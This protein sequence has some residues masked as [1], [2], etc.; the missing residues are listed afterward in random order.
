MQT[1]AVEQDDGIPVV[2]VRQGY[3]TLSPAC[4]E[5][6][7]RILG[8]ELRHGGNPVLRWAAD[9]VVVIS[10]PNGN[11]R[12]MKDKATERIDPLMSLIIAIAADQLVPDDGGLIYEKRGLIAL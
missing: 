3:K 6:E 11:I 1:A 7:R 10:D 9:N 5:L 12:P 4:K 8:E 2:E